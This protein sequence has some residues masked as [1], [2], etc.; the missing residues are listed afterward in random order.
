MTTTGLVFD[1][2]RYAIHDGPGI[3]T[4]VFLKGCPLRCPW[5]QNPESVRAG[6][7][8][9]FFEQRCV[10]CGTCEQ[11]CPEDAVD[12]AT[13]RP[14]DE[15]CTRCGQCTTT[16]PG[17]AREIVG[18]SMSVEEVV[19]AVERDTVFHDES[20]GGVTFSGGEPLLQAEF[21]RA[22]LIRLRSFGCHTAV[23][24][25]G[26]AREEVVLDIAVHADLFLYDLKLMDARRHEQLVGV[27]NEPILRNLRAV[28]ERGTPVWI[29][30]PLLPGINDDEQNLTQ[31][32]EFLRDLR[33]DLP[34]QLLPYHRV[35]TGKLDR[36]QGHQT[37]V[38]GAGVEVGDVDRVDGV[39]RANGA[40][41][42]DRS[43]GSD[44]PEG[45]GDAQAG[46][47]IDPMN[48]KPPTRE[49]VVA[50]QRRLVEL[51]LNVSI[52]G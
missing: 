14:V 18:T 29:R 46:G 3:R 32:A 1:I 15:R 26:F 36:L 5:C 42:S 16:C 52:G 23:D 13:R 47:S 20:G 11:V 9:A 4:T 10:R 27:S 50:V 7:E 2:K 39:D 48:L 19:R 40:D 25:T 28:V 24:T 43:D 8:V 38:E 51:G 6:A 49:H 17:M 34:V 33:A 12:P 31:L 21:L 30:V 37:Q 45:T 41:G 35:G 22:C 44:Q